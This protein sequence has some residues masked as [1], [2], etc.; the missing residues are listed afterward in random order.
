MS[1]NELEPCDPGSSQQNFCF[2]HGTDRFV[3]VPSKK[4]RK[5]RSL[6]ACKLMILQLQPAD[7][8]S[9][10]TF[11]VALAVHEGII[12]SRAWLESSLQI[13][14]DSEDPLKSLFVDGIL[15]THFSATQVYIQD[16]AK[17]FLQQMKVWLA[18][19]VPEESEGDTVQGLYLSR[20]DTIYHASR[21]HDDTTASFLTALVPNDQADPDPLFQP[22]STLGS[23]YQILAVA[24]PARAPKTARLPLQGLRFAVKDA[25]SLRGLKTSLCNAAYLSVSSPSDQ[26]ARIVLKTIAAGAQVVGS[27]KLSS[28][29]GREEPTEATDYL[30]PF[31]PRGDGYQSPAGSSSGSAAAVAAYPWLDFSIGT[32]TTGSGRRPALVNGVFQVRPTYDVEFLDGITPVYKPWDAPALFTRDINLLKPI[33]ATWYQ[34]KDMSFTHVP[35]KPLV[36]IYPLDY[37]PM[38]NAYQMHCIDAFLADLADSLNTVIRRVSIASTWKA[39]PPQHAGGV[40][41]QDYLDDVFVNANFH[42]YY[43]HSTDEFRKKYEEQ[44]DKQPYVI[45][46]VT[47]KWELGKA[48]TQEEREEALHRLDVY[49]KWFLDSIM[50]QGTQESFLVMPI[51]EVVVNYRD[52]HPP[53]VHQ[54]TGFDPLILSPILGA[55]DVVVPIGE[56]EYESRVSGRKEYLPV[57]VDIVGLP[58]SDF[59]LIDTIESCLKRSN[60]PAAVNTGSRLFGSPR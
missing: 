18:F 7:V 2:D 40:S 59:R 29:I 17:V 11:F 12:I 50:H 4:V 37:L 31:N 48:V 35:N 58:G 41:V 14:F 53:P 36:I 55:P 33:L 52:V 54:P 10:A 21:L 27:T 34:L 3:A 60:R 24:V 15:L 1:C 20:H 5:I 26:T 30:S 47:W 22:L 39:N 13:M 16:D 9:S 28:M 46:F 38:K 43:Y 44:Y 42:D 32:D 57:A 8:P 6:I 19:R 45:P 56:F 49:K 23:P 51:S 25:I